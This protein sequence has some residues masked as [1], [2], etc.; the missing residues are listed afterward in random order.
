MYLLSCQSF[1][2][3]TSLL[4]FMEQN[5]FQ[6]QRGLKLEVPGSI[7]TEFM[8]GEGYP[9]CILISDGSRKR[10]LFICCFDGEAICALYLF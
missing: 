5:S 3:I 9:L 10:L 4:L 6:S 1:Y 2:H 7:L 8:E